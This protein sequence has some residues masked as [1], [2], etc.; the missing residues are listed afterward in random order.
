MLKP[1]NNELIHSFIYRLH[2]LSGI[3][4]F[5]NLVNDSGKWMTFPKILKGTISYYDYIYE[6]LILLMLQHIGLAKKSIHCFDNPASYVRDL[7]QFF[8]LSDYHTGS[9]SGPKP[10][11]YCLDCIRKS[12]RD[13]GFA[14]FRREWYEGTFCNE[15]QCELSFVSETSKKPAIHALGSLFLGK[16]PDKFEVCKQNRTS[17]NSEKKEV[18][19]AEYVTPCF[20]NAFRNFIIDKRDDFPAD[21][22]NKKYYSDLNLQQRHVLFSLYQ[23]LKELKPLIYID[24][25]DNN[26]ERKVI[27]TGVLKSTSLKECLLKHKKSSCISCDYSRSSCALRFE[28]SNASQN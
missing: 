11:K 13:N 1:Q 10:I 22:L 17:K 20:V 12:I 27:Y 24:F 19:L 25:L 7:N 8:L 2:K 28:S 21:L 26:T 23:K 18:F 6:P 4:D 3:N 15:H 16:C 14:Y 9:Q 5:R